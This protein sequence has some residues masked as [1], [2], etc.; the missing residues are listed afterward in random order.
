M[1]LANDGGLYE[2]YD[3]GAT[4]RFFAKPSDLAVLPRLRW[5]TRSPSTTSAAARRTTGRSAARRARTNRWACARATGSSSRRRTGSRPRNEP[6]GP[7]TIYA[8]S[9]DEHL[10][11]RRAD[12][13]SSPVDPAPA[14]PRSA[15]GFGGGGGR[16]DGG[17]AP[18]RGARR[19]PR[20]GGRGGQ[21]GAAGRGDRRGR[22]AAATR[23]T[24]MRRTSS[25]PPLAERLTGQQ[26]GSIERRPRATRGR[27]S[28]PDL[29]RNLNRDEIRSWAS[30][31]PADSIARNTSPPPQ[32]HRVARESP[33]L[34]G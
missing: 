15:G 34:E 11:L 28:A 16:C 20:T 33:L 26:T 12:S 22:A 25:A 17:G 5:T 21:A 7:N 9:Q 27:S 29:S 13:A 6:G 31:G 2:S 19:P 1:L 8:S 4:W 14:N 24:G 10:R 32:Q 30:C 18:R 3:E 23:A